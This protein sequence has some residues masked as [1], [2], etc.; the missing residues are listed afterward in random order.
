MKKICYKDVLPSEWCPFWQVPKGKYVEWGAGG[1]EAG[2]R[3]QWEQEK[4]RRRGMDWFRRAAGFVLLSDSF[5]YDLQHLGTARFLGEGGWAECV[6]CVWWS[7]SWRRIVPEVHSWTP[8]FWMSVRKVPGTPRCVRRL[9][10]QLQS[11]KVGVEKWLLGEALD[12]WSF[13]CPPHFL[14]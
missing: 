9:Q 8:Q 6:A 2:A 5:H 10:S 11:P 12:N 3:E 14:V 7:G 1:A 4:S 13:V